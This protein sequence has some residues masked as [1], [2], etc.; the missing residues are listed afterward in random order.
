MT[1]DFDAIVLTVTIVWLAG[2]MWTR[3]FK[4]GDQC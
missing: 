4:E 3:G 2:H 1:V